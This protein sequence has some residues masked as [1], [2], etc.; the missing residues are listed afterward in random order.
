MWPVILTVGAHHGEADPT[1]LAWIKDLL[2]QLIGLE[3]WT[4]VVMIGLLILSMPVGLAV[5][6]LIQQRR[7]VSNTRHPRH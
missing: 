6:Y 4:V 3:P 2:D 5:F 7:A 1:L